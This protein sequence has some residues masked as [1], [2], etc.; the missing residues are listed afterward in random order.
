MTRLAID[1]LGGFRARMDGEK[2]AD[3]P[4]RK[5]QALLAYL[6]SPPGR[7]HRRETLACLLWGEREETKARHS[8]SQ[9]LCSIRKALADGAPSVVAADRDE[10]ALD[11]EAVRVDVG[12]F[13]RLLARETPDAIEE[14]VALYRGDLLAGL[15]ADEEPFE[16][17]LRGE[18]E[19][20]RS[21]ALEAMSRLL[22][23]YCRDGDTGRG[24]VLARRI[25][26]L[27]PLREDAHRALIRLYAVSGQRASAL[28]QYERCRETLQREL[29]VAP[30]PET[31]AEYRRLLAPHGDA[32]AAGEAAPAPR[33]RPSIVVLPFVDRGGDGSRDYI[34][35]GVTDD[36]IS[37]LSRFRALRV[38][39]SNTSFVFKDREVTALEFGRE[40]GVDYV[41]QGS[42][43][44]AGDRLRVTAQLVGMETGAHLWAERYDR[45]TAD[46]FEVQDDVSR[47]IVATMVG[48]IESAGTANARRKPT[49][50]MTAYDYLLRGLEQYRTAGTPE[51]TGAARRLLAKATE[52]DQH[53]ARAYAVLA[54]ID[55]YGWWA[56]RADHKM[57]E[58]LALARKAVALDPDDC[59]GHWILGV[60]VLYARA[61]DEAEYHLE[62]AQ[63]L[64]PNNVVVLVKRGKVLAHVGRAEEAVGLIEQ[65]MA[66]DPYHADWL[67]EELGFALLVAGHY[68]EA[69]QAL[70]RAGTPW[71][72]ECANLAAA[73][74]GSGRLARAREV[75]AGI[76]GER[77]DF[78]LAEVTRA[79]PF[80]RASDRERYLE[81]LS[82]A[83]LPE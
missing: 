63:A 78:D 79:V 37:G 17:W 65:A 19:R 50:N 9:A 33:M 46:I 59:E 49:A 44:V 7:A 55:C 57:V 13:E 22:E 3:L 41:L 64:N 29:G 25:L 1:L 47:S 82:L 10:V 54:C 75:V 77:P 42:A 40:L 6:A 38:M 73:Y 15:A 43:Q 21:L 58:P 48:R 30:E 83:G 51:Q 53:L 23:H 5:T 45:A 32:H 36:I 4:T 16:D 20:L 24:T 61:F 62:R 66:L 69:A 71:P 18:R 52:L 14:A 11:S 80:K 56:D 67:W 35:H 34:A 2:E 68:D 8:L 27:D 70:V 26:A 81:L 31:M 12:E 39:A 76:L 74:A 28:R 60:L 72:Y